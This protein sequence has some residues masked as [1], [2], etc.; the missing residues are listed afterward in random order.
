MQYIQTMRYYSTIKRNEILIEV[1]AWANLVNIISLIVTEGHI[2]YDSTYMK[3]PEQVN[4]QRQKVMDGLQGMMGVQNTELLLNG[5][6]VFFWD[7]KSSW[8]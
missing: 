8:W 3:Y 6:G 5:Y 4:L 2:L 7:V 1:T